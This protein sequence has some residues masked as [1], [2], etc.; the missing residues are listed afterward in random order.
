[1][2]V[3]AGESLV[4]LLVRP[5]GSVEAVPGGGPFNTARSLARLGVPTAFVGR[6]ST[7]RFGRILRERLVADGVDLRWAAETDDPTLL[8]IAELDESGGATYRFHAAGSAAAGLAAADLPAELPPEVAAVHV[9][10]LGL[11]LEPMA[12]A[13]EAL[14]GLVGDG[15][16]VFV[17]LNVRRAAIA[18]PAAYRA[19]L[20]RVLARAN[21]VKA[22]ADDLAW[23]SPGVPAEAAATA[24]ARD[25]SATVLLTDGDAPVR[26]VAPDAVDVLPVPR[27]PVVDTVGA[28][29]A[30]GAGFLAAW[31]RTGLRRPDLVDRD[32]VAR[33]TAFAIRVGAASTMRAGAT[34]PTVDEVDAL[35]PGPA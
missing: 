15:V 31:H 18:D 33:A 25:R 1:M 30:F 3:V 4:D 26:V 21:V 13:V 12:S 17:D 27:V 16:L 14:V 8:A 11:V 9:G 2:I 29:D 19:R 10:T 35:V 24:L 7:D 20:D 28:G 23:R 34:P 5:D 6:L 32:A 22:S